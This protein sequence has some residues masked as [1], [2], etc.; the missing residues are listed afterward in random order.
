M[1]DNFWRQVL[2]KFLGCYKNS[3]AINQQ[4]W[5]QC[6]YYVW[7]TRKAY[8]WRGTSAQ[9]NTCLPSPKEHILKINLCTECHYIHSISWHT[10]APLSSS[11]TKL[12]RISRHLIETDKGAGEICLSSHDACVQLVLIDPLSFVTL[13]FLWKNLRCLNYF[14]CPERLK[15]SPSPVLYQW[16]DSKRTANE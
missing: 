7:R 9:G 1:H 2:K 6:M 3:L 8:S 4:N 12:W 11:S 5:N 15:G 14:W 13:A 16:L 10:L